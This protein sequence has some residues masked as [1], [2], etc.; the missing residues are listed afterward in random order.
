MFLKVQK[1][2]ILLALTNDFN[3]VFQAKYVESEEQNKTFFHIF[4]YEIHMESK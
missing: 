2:K 4:R 1:Q 3:L